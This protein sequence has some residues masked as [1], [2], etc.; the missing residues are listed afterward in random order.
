[1]ARSSSDFGNVRTIAS[2]PTG[3]IIA[4]PAPCTTRAAT[5]IGALTASPH[6]TEL[7][8]KTATAIA[9]TRRLPKRSA[10]HPLIGMHTARLRM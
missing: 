4:A 3:I 8:V 7:S 6:S 2:R 9:N 5:S 10:I 1:M